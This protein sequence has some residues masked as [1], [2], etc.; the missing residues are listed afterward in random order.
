MMG[1]GGREDF[2][3]MTKNPWIACGSTKFGVS[4]TNSVEYWRPEGI[5]IFISSTED[6]SR[7][8]KFHLTYPSTYLATFP[9]FQ[10]I[11]E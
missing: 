4:G 8:A 11:E 3:T 1:G 2:H 10:I 7:R 9:S 6:M 5:G